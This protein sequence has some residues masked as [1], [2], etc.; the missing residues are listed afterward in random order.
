VFQSLTAFATSVGAP[1]SV[2]RFHHSSE[3]ESRDGSTKV[4]KVAYDMISYC[5]VS[6]RISITIGGMSSSSS[7][8]RLTNI[9]CRIVVWGAGHR[10]DAF[11]M[12]T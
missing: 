3:A 5:A 6:F 11:G 4:I 7:V 9:L 12:K 1:R 8:V 10:N 2:A